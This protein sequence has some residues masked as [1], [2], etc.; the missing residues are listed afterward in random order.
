MAGEAQA[1]AARGRR[2][3]AFAL[4]NM[5]GGGAERVA[6]TLMKHFLGLGHEVDLVLVK[7]E[8]VL[9][10]EVPPE[11]T[12]VDLGARRIVTALPGFARYLRRR[13]PDALQVRMWPLTVVALLARRLARVATR[14]VTSD[15]VALTQ[16]YGHL[17]RT[18]RLLKA[19]V[20]AFYPWADARLLVSAGAADDIAR[21]SGLPRSAF[22][23]VYN[24][25]PPVPQASV[26]PEVEALWRGATD[27]I[28]TVGTLK[29]QKNQALLIDA[30]ARLRRDR[31]ARLM[32][33]GTGD[34]AD[35]LKAQAD[36]LGVA[37]DVLFPGFA[38]D[39]TPYMAS[40][41]LFVLSSDYEGFGN[42]L[43]EAMGQGVSVVST[44]CQSGPSEILGDGRYGALVRCGDAEALARAM[45]HAL[46]HPTDPV[47]LRAQ[48]ERISG[49]GSLDRYVEL[50]LGPQSAKRPPA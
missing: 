21:I 23:V 7:A 37:Q 41:R 36:R 26:P 20:R 30:F 18:F 22:Q 44:D 25:K 38:P 2:R 40:A 5:G 50:L 3:V 8:G 19:T 46:D 24:P 31:P 35:A 28:I 42:V 32:L 6:I 49:Q 11:V 13:R 16:Q 4:P 39:P 34:L 47:A 17:P 10:A 14:I 29:P 43:V 48:A 45:A 1:A 27:R 12:V 15:H 9:L 33:L